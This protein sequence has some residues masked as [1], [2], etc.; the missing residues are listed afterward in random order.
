VVFG[1]F[2]VYPVHTLRL[3]QLINRGD[4]ET[5]EDLLRK[6]MTDRFA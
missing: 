4:R 3:D 6:G 5:S 1:L 2:G